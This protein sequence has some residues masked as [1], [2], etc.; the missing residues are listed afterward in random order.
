MDIYAFIA[1]Y[2]LWVLGVVIALACACI[3][4]VCTAGNNHIEEK[5]L[6]HEYE[7]KYT[8]SGFLPT[9]SS[10]QKRSPNR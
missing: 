1:Q 7:G 4:I 9:G 8:A 2:I 10:V 3:V 5:P 6:D